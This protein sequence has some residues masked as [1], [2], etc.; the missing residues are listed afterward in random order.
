MNGARRLQLRCALIATAALFT[1][2]AM[3]E[4]K[5]EPSVAPRF[6]P[7]VDVVAAK[8]LVR[9]A[10]F[11]CGDDHWSSLGAPTGWGGDL[12]GLYGRVQSDDAAD[13][14][15]CLVIELG[16]RKTPETC[17]DVWPPKR[18]V[19]HAPLTAEI[20][21]MTV[22][23]GQPIT[24]SAYLKSSVPDTKARFLFRYASN[25]L[26]AV[27]Q[28][29]EERVVSTEW[30]RY[31]VTQTALDEDV[32][33]AIGPDMTAMPKT[34]VV[35]RIDAVQLEAGSAATPFET[36]EPLELGFS[37]SRYGNVFEAG[38]PAT[39]RVYAHNRG[40]NAADVSLKLE[41]EDF[42]GAA[43]EPRSFSI[44]VPA[45]G[46]T[47]QD[48]TLPAHG[49]G[50]YRARILWS[51]GGIEHSYPLKFAVV[52][53]Y[54][55]DDSPFGLNHP[56]TTTRQLELLS[57]AGLRWVRN[58]SVNWQWV[59]STPGNVSWETQDAQ[60]DFMVPTGL[61]NL[62]VFPNPSTN[63]D[64]SAPEAVSNPM[65][66]RMAYAPKDPQLLCG[67]IGAA[68]RRYKDKC[69]YWEFLNEPLW[70]PDFCLPA[71]AG[72]NVSDYISLLEGASKAIREA[73]PDGRIIAGLSIEP[74]MPLGDEFITAGGLRLCDILN[75]H[76]YGSL[77]VPEEF[78]KD[79][80]RV[81]AAMDAHGGRKPIW[82]T[83]TG[84]YAVDDKP[85][86]P[87]AVPK[88]HFSAA[89]LLPNER[90]AAE[91][92]VRHAII[93]LAHGVE[94]LFYHEP[95]HGAVNNGAMDIENPFLAEEGVPKKTYVALSAL[96][97][98][99]GPAPRYECEATFPA[100]VSNTG[101]RPIGYVFQ[102]GA[103][104]V[105][106]V[107]SPGTN[108]PLDGVA[109]PPAVTACNIV[110]NELPGKLAL[111][112]SPIFLTS[113]SLTA[114]E[115]AKGWHIGAAAPAH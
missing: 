95:I 5:S 111:G 108:V 75:L 55:H 2:S 92:V 115:L 34:D 17:F 20:G 41:W 96:A 26:G 64:S 101:A 28:S 76:P 3:S 14:R 25:A 19:Q 9:N 4:E 113:D 100:V 37:T 49:K 7:R 94:K 24:L 51:A 23:R 38:Q 74:R 58:W 81:Q 57:R 53:S 6:Q 18:V 82:A 73:D 32:C 43:L 93:L 114:G 91:Y 86:Q 65:W 11:E 71:S 16:P 80:E 50:H 83:E 110:G 1:T 10:S 22:P 8:N 88:G 12:S 68:V 62:I 105:A 63:W 109:L 52:E 15:S 107:W 97:N 72:Y 21:W 66:G 60:F 78:I 35:F 85:W 47:E 102:C 13:G 79:M 39:I 77:T 45:A 104:A 90:V 59:E 112:D 87:W 84:Y 44:H 54:K 67:F 98:L 61:K 46:Q 36:R 106:I 42:F 69:R 99:L 40:G 29:A 56:A 30:K 27:Q 70:V 31:S 48:W 89:L 103:K 33:I